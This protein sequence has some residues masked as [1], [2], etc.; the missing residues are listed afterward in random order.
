MEGKRYAAG[1]CPLQN[2]LIS[3]YFYGSSFVP[4]HTNSSSSSEGRSPFSGLPAS[5]RL[6]PPPYTGFLGSISWEYWPGPSLFMAVH[7]LCILLYLVSKAKGFLVGSPARNKSSL[8][9]AF[10][11][12]QHGNPLPPLLSEAQLRQWMF[13]DRFWFHLENQKAVVP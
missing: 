7:P 6:V 1:P 4:A 11:A 2:W 3:R 12:V 5:W 13:E 8:C 9:Q 10:R